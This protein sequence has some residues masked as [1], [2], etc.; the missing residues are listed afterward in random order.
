MRIVSWGHAVFTATMIGLG[1]MGLIK[2]DFTSTWTGVP[3]SLPLRETLVYM[4]ALISIVCG[5]GLL[6]E[7]TAVV[8]SRVLLAYLVLWFLLFRVPH[9]FI[10]PTAI[11]TWWGLGDTAV[12]VAAAWALYACF[13]SGRNGQRLGFASGEKGLLVARAFYGLALI[14]FGVAH[15]TN[16][17]ETIAL[18]PRWLPWHVSW[19]YFTGAAFIVA[20]VAVLTGVCARLAATLSAWELGL[21]TLIVWVPIV[22]SGANAFQWTEFLTSWVLTAGAWVVADSYRDTRWLATGKLQ[23]PIVGA[24]AAE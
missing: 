5:V 20:G 18:I 2:G 6:L 10:V 4:S 12:M 21:F 11:D 3:R 17:K 15:F 24:Q 19:A 1:V 16:V 7:R 8:A 9:I 22:A 13:A 23:L 14:P